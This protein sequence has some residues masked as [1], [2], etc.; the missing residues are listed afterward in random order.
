MTEAKNVRV[1][2]W[3]NT[4]FRRHGTCRKRA[5]QAG[6]DVK[7]GVAEKKNSLAVTTRS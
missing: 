7:S 4:H 3:K 2:G 1:T 6:E 5:E